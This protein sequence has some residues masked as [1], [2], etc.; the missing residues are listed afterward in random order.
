MKEIAQLFG[1]DRNLVGTLT[2]PDTPTRQPVAFLLTGAGVIHRMGPH[3]IN[4]KL[5]RHLASLGFATLRF[6]LSGQGDSRS[7]SS[8]LNFADQAVSDMRAAM[9]HLT[10]TLDVQRFAITGICSGADVAFATAQ[11]DPRACGVF[12][13]DGYHYPTEKTAKMRWKHRLKGS[14]L[15]AIGPWLLRRIKRFLTPSTPGQKPVPTYGRHFP[16]IEIYATALQKLV[17]QGTQVYLLFSGSLLTS[18]NYAEQFEEAFAG[19]AFVKKVD[20]HYAAGIDHTVTPLAAQ[21]ELIERVST[22]AG[23]LT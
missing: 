9:D 12:M 14:I 3:R 15:S 16:A 22:W 21:R 23:G 4:V 20:A 5:A 17:D 18:Y 7:T 19:H 1:A 8:T 2:L 6:D 13:I 10:R 11:A